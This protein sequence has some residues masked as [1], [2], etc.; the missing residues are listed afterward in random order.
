MAPPAP[1]P[2][3][4]SS[5]QLVE[6]KTSDDNRKSVPKK[7]RRISL[8]PPYKAPTYTKVNMRSLDQT[9]HDLKKSTKQAINKGSSIP[10]GLNIK[11]KEAIWDSC[12]RAHPLLTIMSNLFY[13]YLLL[14]SVQSNVAHNGPQS[15]YIQILYTGPTHGPSL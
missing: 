10:D 1:H 13:N 6:L 7:S 5:F 8:K 11:Y 9:F 12:G 2:E 4:P 15:R 14:R 3:K